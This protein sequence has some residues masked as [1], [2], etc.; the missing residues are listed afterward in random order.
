[1]LLSPF[2]QFFL[3]SYFSYEGIHLLNNQLHVDYGFGLLLL[4]FIFSL[5]GN[6]IQ[7][8][9]VQL[10][11]FS[12]I[13]KNLYKFF[14]EIVYSYLSNYVRIYFSF[15]FFLFLFIFY[16][17]LT[18]LIPY[19]F[20]VTSHFAIT[21]FFAFMIWY[22][23]IGIGITNHQLQFFLIFFPKGIALGLTM[24]ITC[25]E[26]LSYSFRVISLAVRLGAN[27]IAGHIMIDCIIIYIYNLVLYSLFLDGNL[28][29]VYLFIIFFWFLLLFG[30]MLYEVVVCFLQAYIFIVLSCLYIKEVL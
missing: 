20:T 6:Y 15:L 25:L 11:L 3:Y 13:I 9:V 10:N 23:A 12:Y 26:L 24:L 30:F 16:C 19:N 22:G 4:F 21:F 2:E 8:D 27:M 17:N 5:K 29:L 7:N 1:M 14:Y 18:G 28:I